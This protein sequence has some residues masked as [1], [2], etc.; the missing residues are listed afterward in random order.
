METVRLA[1]ALFVLLPA[2]AIASPPGD[3]IELPKKTAASHRELS[4]RALSRA[5]RLRE[6]AYS[7]L[8]TPY[9][10]GGTTRNGIDCSGY[11]RQMFRTIY[12]LELPRTTREQI[13]LG[14]AVTLDPND[15]GKGLEPGDLFFYLDRVGNTTHV[16]TY[17]GEGKFT[18]SASGRG[19]VIEG[20]KALW[21][22]RIVGRRV[23]VPA[24]GDGN[25][26][27]RGA[28]PA[29]API[30]P[31]EVP[32]P[33]TVRA[34][35]EEVRRFR[36]EPIGSFAGYADREICDWRALKSALERATGPASADN[37]KRIDVQID[38]LERIDSLKEQLD[39]GLE[40]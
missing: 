8:G 1:A 19:V 11:L 25:I 6:F 23:L 5:Q 39:P 36:L 31:L 15:L 7:W 28:I 34:R 4:G 10:W 35:D 37:I 29:A 24:T 12:D 14:T 40:R 21:G 13:N 33:P 3:A 30:Q 38:W 22:R 26:A 16:V 2:V 9:L 17:I 32:C 20:F 18:H 27:A